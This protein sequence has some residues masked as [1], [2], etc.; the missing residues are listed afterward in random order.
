MKV[1]DR[2]G[3]NLGVALVV[4]G[5][6]LVL[7]RSLHFHGPG[8]ILLLIGA[9]LLTVSAFRDFR[10]PLVAAGV[11]LGLGTGFLLRDPLEPWVPGWATLLFGIGAGL[12]LASSFDRSAGRERRPTA[13][14][15]GVIL[16]GIAAV[17]AASANLRIPE[18]LYDL[19]W[20]YWPMAL[21]A[22]GALIVVQAFRGNRRLR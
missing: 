11:L 2:R 4:L 9:G 10:G 20:R 7:K 15:P 19:V 14:V 17:T 21:I 5:V 6:Y 16:I 12:V 22:A 8:P 18:N 13:L 1:S 3:L